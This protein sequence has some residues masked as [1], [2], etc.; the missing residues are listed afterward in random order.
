MGNIRQRAPSPLQP[1]LCEGSRRGSS[2]TISMY[3][4]PQQRLIC[5][6]NGK[7]QKVHFLHKI[8]YYPARHIGGHLTLLLETN[9]IHH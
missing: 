4:N 3:P 1:K 9:D 7:P 5:G 2:V 8:L 6:L